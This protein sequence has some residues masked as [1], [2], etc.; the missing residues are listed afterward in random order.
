MTM[1]GTYKVIKAKDPE[2]LR[3]SGAELKAMNTKKAKDEIRRRA[4]NKAA[5]RA[6][7]KG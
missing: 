7:Q 4:D 2:M 5:K 1:A 3:F 6:A